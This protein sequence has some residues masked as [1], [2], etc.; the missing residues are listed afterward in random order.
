M[1]LTEF[2]SKSK[3]TFYDRLLQQC[4]DRIY[5]KWDGNVL[6]GAVG[7]AVVLPD[8]DVV[9]GVSS[10]TKDGHW[11]HAEREAINK[12]IAKYGEVPENSKILSTLEPCFDAMPN[13]FG[14]SCSELIGQ[15]NIE[16]VYCG[17][18]DDMQRELNPNYVHPFEIEYSK[19]AG[20]KF[21]CDRLY[22]TIPPVNTKP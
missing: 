16:F 14:C 3:N 1:K 5:F 21:Q 20:I 6:S 22:D 4:L 11:I 8:G 9:F 12:V 17:L 2:S 15:H 10:K 7:A 19:D 18:E 13:R